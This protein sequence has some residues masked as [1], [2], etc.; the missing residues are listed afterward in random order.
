MLTDQDGDEEGVAWEL[1]ELMETREAAAEDND[2]EGID[3]KATKN[4]STSVMSQD[5]TIQTREKS[6]K[7][8]K[9]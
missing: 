1:E 8:E 5:T 2:T 6:T 7:E 4:F 9:V 3:K